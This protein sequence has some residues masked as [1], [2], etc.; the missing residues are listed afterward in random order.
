MN[1][2]FI[3]T[4][5]FNKRMMGCY[6]HPIV[7]TPNLDR[8]AEHGI[9]FTNAYC[10]SPV[11]VPSRASVATGRYIHEIETWDN[12]KP[13]TGQAPSWGHRL[14]EQ[15]HQV[16]TIGKLHYRNTDD[17]TG[18]NDQRIP[19]HIH[20][21]VGHIYSLLRD[22]E[23]TF[24]QRSTVEDAGVGESSYVRYDRN[25]TE[26]TVA[27]LANEAQTFDKPWTLFV[28]YVCPH[29]PLTA[30]EPYYSM[31][32]MDDVIFPDHY[33]MDER[34]NHPVIRKMQ[35]FRE[36]DDAMDEHVVRRALVSYYALCS[37]IDDQIGIV[38]R[39]LEETGLAHNTRIVFTSDHGEMAGQQGMW[40][41][42]YMYEGSAGIPFIVSGPDL[43]KGAVSDEPMSLVDCFP[44]IV[45]AVG[46]RLTNEDVT[47]PGISLFEFMLRGHSMQRTVF[48]EYHG[49]GAITGIYMIR[50]GRYK[51]VHYE[52]Y[53]PQLFDLVQDPDEYDDLAFKQDYAQL[54]TICEQQLRHICDPTDVNRMAHADQS[55]RIEL[56]GGLTQAMRSD[57]PVQLS[58]APKLP[59]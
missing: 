34:P 7:R 36:M 55:K 24:P 25:I 17:Q 26:Q 32:S 28:S 46:C 8:L 48:S 59:Q 1:V 14:V 52:G 2:L 10:N 29:P 43:P 40:Y 37:F 9:R 39:K 3:M 33:Q 6:G 53:P 45:E 15:G 22:G 35:Q 13:Y 16:T 38:L 18:F 47:L 23:T 50:Y 4:D 20:N 42:S 21:G 49:S 31:Y 51:Y 58:P 11:C 57:K 12:A 44:T 5:E 27:F 41:K 54:L 56:M 19:L 30:P